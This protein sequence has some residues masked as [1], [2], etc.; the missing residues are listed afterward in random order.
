MM[1]VNATPGERKTAIPRGL[2]DAAMRNIHSFSKV[3]PAFHLS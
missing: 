3:L 1:T 2:S